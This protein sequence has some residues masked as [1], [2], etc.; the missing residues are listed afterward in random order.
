LVGWDGWL[1]GKKSGGDGWLEGDLIGRYGW[2]EGE[3][4]GWDGWLEGGW[5]DGGGVEWMVTGMVVVSCSGME[6][7]RAASRAAPSARRVA[8][9]CAVC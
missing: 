7:S 9:A 6:A 5:D 8:A 1:E 4:S 2:L 3:L